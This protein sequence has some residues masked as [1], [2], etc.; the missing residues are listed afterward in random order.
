MLVLLG[1]TLSGC[2]I[3]VR[4]DGPEGAWVRETD[5]WRHRQ[6]RN[7]EAVAHLEL[8]RTLSSITSELGAPD[9][10]EAFVR[11]GH[12]FRVL[13]YRSRLMHEDGRTTRNETTPLV[14]VDGELVGWG[15][16][17]IEYALP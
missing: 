5:D 16:S 12:S 1:L 17:A 15:E 3:S 10:T 14:F 7:E 11:D 13:F 4:D 9:M 2:Y 8:G 6:E